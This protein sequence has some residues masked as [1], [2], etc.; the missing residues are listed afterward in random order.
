MSSR[1]DP[2]NFRDIDTI[3]VPA[4][5]QAFQEVFLGEQ[6]WYAIDISAAL[7][8]QIKHIAVYQVAPESA[9]THVAAVKSI[10][11]W[12]DSRRSVVNF[13]G[14][15]RRIGPVRVGMNRRA[16]APQSRRYT[17]LRKLEAAKTL[18]D[19]W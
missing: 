12:R 2:A 8:S 16:T 4:Q 15:P 3:V 17:S 10:E 13:A 19:L 11:P 6:R 18:D 7:Q 5:P 14:P 1:L 9:I